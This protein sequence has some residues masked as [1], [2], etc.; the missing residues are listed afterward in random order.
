MNRPEFK[1]D[2]RSLVPVSAISKQGYVFVEVRG[3][4]IV[5][6]SLRRAHAETRKPSLSAEKSPNKKTGDSTCGV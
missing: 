1:F 6:P 2:E 5:M 3:G 4:L